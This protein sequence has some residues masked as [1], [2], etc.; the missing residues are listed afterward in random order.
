MRG[1]GKYI[2]VKIN[3]TIR[4]FKWKQD[5]N[6]NDGVAMQIPEKINNKC[7]KICIFSMVSD[8]WRVGTLTHS[9][10]NK[11]KE[12]GF[13]LLASSIIIHYC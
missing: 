12:R 2:M 1:K 7:Q 9:I 8:C 3:N 13:R 4:S 11:S 10:F 6:E 5:Y